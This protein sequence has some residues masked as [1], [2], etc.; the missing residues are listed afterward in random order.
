MKFLIS[1]I[2]FLVF[3]NAAGRLPE[4]EL[5]DQNT[6]TEL[7]NLATY[8]K[9]ERCI[10]KA[11]AEA[12]LGLAADSEEEATI[13]L[14]CAQNEANYKCLSEGLQACYTPDEA[15]EFGE[16]YLDKM[17]TKLDQKYLD[18][19][20]IFSGS[21]A[22]DNEEFG[23]IEERFSDNDVARRRRSPK[24]FPSPLDQIAHLYDLPLYASR[25]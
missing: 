18:N 11:G 10:L 6:C 12:L 17:R 19:C 22:S 14:I 16:I 8:R 25:K 4:S 1:F 24:F 5:T 21:G 23:A 13:E 7:E 15:K 9:I 2:F 20:P 3:K